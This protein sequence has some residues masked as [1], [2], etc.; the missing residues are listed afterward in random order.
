MR[1]IVQRVASLDDVGLFAMKYQKLPSVEVSEAW[2]YRTIVDKYEKK[3]STEADAWKNL[4]KRCDSRTKIGDHPVYA[5]DSE[6]SLF[7]NSCPWNM[8][9]FTTE[10]SIINEPGVEL[11]MP[12]INC[13][14]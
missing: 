11:K 13:W 8:N 6:V 4:E 9:H 7:E 10:H 2:Q 12:G 5:I 14:M 1:Q 3:H